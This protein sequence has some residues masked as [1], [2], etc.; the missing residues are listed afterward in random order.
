MTVARIL[1]EKGRN[2]ITVQE[3][4]SLLEVSEIL[5]QNKI[6]STVVTNVNEEIVGIV[7][8]RDIVRTLGQEGLDALSKPISYCMT[9]EVVTCFETATIDEVM[10]I[11]SQRRFRHM[12][13][14]ENNKL[15]GII[16]IGD[17]VKIK[18]AETEREAAAMRSYITASGY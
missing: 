15:A 1:K 17:V 10:A 5:T 9:S 14:L 8:E 4:M 12:P 7:S 18:I 2:V 16:S 13:V 11:M 3:T 6:G